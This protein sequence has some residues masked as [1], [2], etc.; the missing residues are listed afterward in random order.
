MKECA[1]DCGAMWDGEKLLRSHVHLARALFFLQVDLSSSLLAP[2]SLCCTK[3]GWCV[4]SQCNQHSSHGLPQRTT[5][6][7]IVRRREAAWLYSFGACATHTKL[8]KVCV[9]PGRVAM[10]PRSV[11]PLPFIVRSSPSPLSLYRITCSRSYHLSARRGGGGL[12]RGASV[13]VGGSFREAHRSHCKTRFLFTHLYIYCFFSLP[14]LS[15][16]RHHILSLLSLPSLSP[17]FVTLFSLGLSPSSSF[18]RSS[19]PI[20]LYR[21]LGRASRRRHPSCARFSD[22]KPAAWS[23]KYRANL[24]LLRINHFL[25]A[26]TRQLCAMDAWLCAWATE[27]QHSGACDPLL[28]ILIVSKLHENDGSEI[29]LKLSDTTFLPFSNCDF[30]NTRS[31][32]V[33]VIYLMSTTSNFT[34][35]LEVAKK[36]TSSQTCNCKS[37]GRTSCTVT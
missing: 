20:L 28:H 10:L 11:V 24:A 2:L 37:V 19:F 36:K 1:S 35:K 6:A 30:A 31:I 27:L 32:R 14:F 25:G 18:S 7:E 17:P 34:W 4:S 21:S 23:L 5:A 16:Q 8:I 9:A 33:F 12:Q 22:H 29:T 13:R 26:W 3:T 15:F